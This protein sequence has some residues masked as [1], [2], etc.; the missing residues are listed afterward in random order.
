MLLVFV[1]HTHTVT[2]TKLTCHTFLPLLS[3]RHCVSCAGALALCLAPPS[4]CPP[5]SF[6]TQ[7]V[8][9]YFML[10][11]EA[12][13]GEHD[14]IAKQKI[15]VQV[16]K[17]ANAAQKLRGK[18]DRDGRPGFTGILWVRPFCP[19]P[20]RK[21]VYRMP[22]AQMTP[23]PHPHLLATSK[24]HEKQQHRSKHNLSATDSVFRQ[25]YM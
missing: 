2:R 1:T 11:Q 5:F 7:V 15:M 8:H 14:W 10:M 20:G 22:T 21:C 17:L 18:G 16:H 19:Y 3:C 23:T 24:T 13:G 12:R 6:P 9:P 25:A 4:V